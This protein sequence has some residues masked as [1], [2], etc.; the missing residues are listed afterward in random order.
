MNT[1]LSTTTVKKSAKVIKH[2]AALATRAEE[3][4]VLVKNAEE[5]LDIYYDMVKK[6]K[7]DHDT[8]MEI[9]QNIHKIRRMVDL[10]Q[11][12]IEQIRC[13]TSDVV[14]LNEVLYSDV[15][16][17]EVVEMI[18]PNK[19]VVRQLDTKLKESAKDNLQ[20][21]FCPGGFVGHFDNGEQEWEISTNESAPLITVQRRGSHPFKLNGLVMTMTTSPIKIYDFNF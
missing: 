10:F 8:K 16:P 20:K 15:N 13:E 19:W 3:L 7:D 6:Y 14:Y 2:Q 4:A 18:T 11:A 5:Q 21:S 1:V 12:E 9:Y 17:Y